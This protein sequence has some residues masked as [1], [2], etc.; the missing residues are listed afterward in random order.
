MGLTT[1]EDILNFKQ[2]HGLK[3]AAQLK[4]LGFSQHQV[5]EIARLLTKHEEQ[6]EKKSNEVPLVYLDDKEK[7]N[8]DAIPG[9]IPMPISLLLDP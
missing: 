7:A 2:E 5:R 8:D 4:K 1:I 9:A 3:A 6:Q